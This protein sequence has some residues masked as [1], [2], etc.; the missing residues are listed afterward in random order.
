[1]K[2]IIVFLVL[3]LALAVPARAELSAWLLT[4]NEV[5]GARVG[6]VNNN[7]EVGGLSYWWY[8]TEPME[9]PQVF[10]AYGA[11]HF[12]DLIEVAN[13]IPVDWLPATLH[14]SP[15]L[16]MQ[17]GINCDREKRDFI[18]PIAGLLLQDLLVIEYQ[19]REYSDALE[20][21]L[22]SG[23]HVVMAGIRIKF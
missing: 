11:Y 2:R 22:G 18:G 23:E 20:A 4:D 8:D 14:A 5:V 12:P 6:Y 1:M 10:G 16:G 19:Y 9:P 13:P 15:Y 3:V 17:I 7:I 21:A